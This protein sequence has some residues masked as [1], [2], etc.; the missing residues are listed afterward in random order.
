MSLNCKEIDRILEE[1]S[2]EGSF[3]QQIVQPAYD[4]L[5]LHTYGEQGAKTVLICLAPGAC[6]IHETRRKVPKNPK[7]LRFM[8]FLRSRIKGG[9]I[10][11]I[12][13]EGSER[14]IRVEILRGGTDPEGDR[15]YMYIRLWSGAANII[16]TGSNGAI[17]DAFYRRPKREELPG[18]VYTPPEQ[19]T[20]REG[21]KPYTV[22]SF[23][24]EFGEDAEGLSFNEKVE[25]WYGE[26]AAALSRTALLEQAEK[27]YQ[28]RRS[29]LEAAIQRLEKKRDSFLHADRWKHYGDLILANLHLLRSGTDFLEC[30]DYETGSN[31]RIPLD[32]KKGGKENA[33]EYYT[34]YK[35]AVSGLTELEDDIASSQRTIDTLKAEFEALSAEQ[36]PLVIRKMLRKQTTPRQQAE[37]KYPG[38]SFSVEGWLFLVGRTAAE[39]DE[40]LRRYMKGFDMWLHARDWS[41]SYVFIKNRPGK[42]IPLEI[43]ID[44]G[45]LAL[46]YSKGRKAGKGDL[47]YTQVKH[48]RRAKNAPKGT[49]LPAHEKNLFVELD[50]SRLKRLE[51]HRL[52]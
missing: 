24:E 4:T 27:H 8:E 29:R 3:I 43:L 38:L 34:T 52:V 6:R 28:V 30:T 42:T 15:F 2:L 5:A 46:F 31:L 26:H 14:I 20:D 25:R 49:V 7:P 44:A 41:G 37:K 33:Q 22:R 9:R 12:G 19:K 48:L 39:N 18:G 32:P 10:T 16:V 11:S 47:Y 1:L 36:N 13:Q 23:A 21:G 51:K 40:L 50:E 45:T 17:L 35:K